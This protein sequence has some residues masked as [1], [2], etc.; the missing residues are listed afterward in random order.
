MIRMS[1]T[2]HEHTWTISNDGDWAHCD[3]G[4]SGYPV[5]VAADNKR[6]A[7]QIYNELREDR[8]RFASA[9]RAIRR[10]ALEQVNTKSPEWAITNTLRGIAITV[11]YAIGINAHREQPMSDTLPEREDQMDDDG[12]TDWCDD[13]HGYTHMPWCPAYKQPKEVMEHEPA[14]VNISGLLDQLRTQWLEVVKERNELRAERR[15]LIDAI[16]D[17]A[18]RSLRYCEEKYD[19]DDQAR[20]NLEALLEEVDQKERSE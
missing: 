12:S 8:Q 1:N 7:E 14:T 4:K 10:K 13:C 11:D 3:C 2:Q 20:L 5:F 16:R 19:H 15:R 6:R 17:V 18:I 9:L